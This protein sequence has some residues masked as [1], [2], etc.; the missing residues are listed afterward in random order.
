MK[1]PWLSS[2]YSQLMLN[3]HTQV[4]I[5]SIST[6]A[7]GYIILK[8]CICQMKM[9]CFGTSLTAKIAWLPQ[10]T[11]N[12]CVEKNISDEGGLF[13]AYTYKYNIHVKD[14]IK[15]ADV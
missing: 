4:H 3:T 2:L 7:C 5:S 15:M 13:I 6:F 11:L 8:D 1:S 10:I 12:V 14:K 9:H